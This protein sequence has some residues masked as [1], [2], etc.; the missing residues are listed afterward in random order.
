MLEL[1]TQLCGSSLFLPGAATALTIHTK[2]KI[3][4]KYE[5]QSEFSTADLEGGPSNVHP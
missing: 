2:A 4:F 1:G 3:E 5:S